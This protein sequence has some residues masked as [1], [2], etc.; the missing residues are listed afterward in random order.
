MIPTK[1][2]LPCVPIYFWECV[3]VF[4]HVESW[5]K[6]YFLL[7]T[8]VE[9]KLWDFNLQKVMMYVCVDICRGLWVLGSNFLLGGACLTISNTQHQTTKMLSLT[10]KE[11]SCP[12]LS[13]NMISAHWEETKQRRGLPT[14]RITQCSCPVL[15]CN[16]LEDAFTQT[17]MWMAP[18]GVEQCTT[19]RALPGSLKYS[20]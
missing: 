10:S 2:W 3:R 18:P 5:C 7:W 13:K 15:P 16:T 1:P 19:Q 6:M 11:K 12:Y 8:V 20:D 17:A 4:V 9:K 14:I